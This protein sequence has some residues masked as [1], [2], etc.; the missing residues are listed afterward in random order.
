MPIEDRIQVVEGARLRFMAAPD[1]NRLLRLAS[2]WSAFFS[3]TWPFCSVGKP[4]ERQ[5]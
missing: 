3:I 4:R 2:H 1:K 5:E